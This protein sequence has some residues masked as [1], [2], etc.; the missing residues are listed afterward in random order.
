MITLES[1]ALVFRFPEVHAAAE[2]RIAFQRTLRIPDDGRDYPL[3]P[4]LGRFP[5]RH[6]EDYA[7]AG[8]EA[9]KRGGV[10]LPMWQAEALWLDFGSR[11]GGYPCAV[12]VFTGM[13]DAITGAPRDESA[14]L[15]GAPQNYVVVPDQPW[16]DGYCIAEGA[17]RQFV[18]MPLGEGFS[19]EEQI[20]GAAAYGG[21]QLEVIP[22]RRER[23]EAWAATQRRRADEATTAFALAPACAAP[24]MGLAPGGRMKQEIYADEHGAA[25]WDTARARRCFVTILNSA[26]WLA[27]T[28]ERPPTEP[29]T[30]ARYNAA[31]LPWFDYYRDDAKALAGS[32]VLGRLESVADKLKG[33]RKTLPGNDSFEPGVTVPLGPKPAPR[34][35][36]EAEF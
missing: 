20:T 19:A 9:A 31:R 4:G 28:G 16:L 33:A 30:A 1:D 26:A 8:P 27:I 17:I 32:G 11:W 21:L 7:A 36:K 23:Y 18:A 14:A 15:A 25:A 12:R 2:C 3:P 5:L 22:M 24:A 6:A 35:V 13:I 34:A 29:P 10:L